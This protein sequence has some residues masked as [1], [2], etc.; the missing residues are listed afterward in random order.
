MRQN[1]RDSHVARNVARDAAAK[2]E[3]EVTVLKGIVAS[4]MATRTPAPAPL[5]ISMPQHAL[6]PPPPPPMPVPVARPQ[7]FSKRPAESAPTLAPL[8]RSQIATLSRASARLY[9]KSI[10]SS[11]RGEP[12]ELR[13]RLTALFDAILTLRTVSLTSTVQA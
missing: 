9:L 3:K 13:S 7:V 1:L 2:A 11:Q 10:G 4:L 5:Q 6:L 8:R 12:E